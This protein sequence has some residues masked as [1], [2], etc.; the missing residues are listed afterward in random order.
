MNA[1]RAGL[2]VLVCAVAMT[3]QTY[4]F[5]PV[6]P[7]A[8][9][10]TT[11]TKKVT[12]KQLKPDLMLLIDKSGSMNDGENGG[13]ASAGNPRKMD[14]LKSVMNTFLMSEGRVARMGMT[15]YPA[16]ATCGASTA[17]E[18]RNG[19]TVASD[20]D[21]D[22]QAQANAVNT[23]LQSLT[24]GGGTPTAL[25]LQF[26]GT[27]PELNVSDRED[28]VLLLTDGL[29]NCNNNNAK[30]CTVGQCTCTVSPASACGMGQAYCTLGCL[31]TDGSVQAI[32][33]LRAKQIR[34]IVVG[35]GSDVAGGAAGDT[36]NAMAIAGGFQRTCPNGTAAECGT[37]NTCL[38]GNVCAKAYYQASNGTELAAALAQISDNLAGDGI[39]KY[40]LEAQP[41]SAD[42][43]SVIIDG[44][45]QQSGP[46]T[47]QLMNGQIVFPDTGA[48]SICAKLKLSDTTKPVTVEIRVVES[49]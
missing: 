3:C 4:D 48:T 1:L 33:D 47:W 2:S 45:P 10:Q 36:L 15:I 46:D 24:P 16:D 23:N 18:V 32:R 20:M 17:N 31:D 9:A 13:P 41:S 43:V 29:P 21:A 28:F 34:T 19:I 26:L 7:L 25:S 6:T 35:F 39:C 38:A 5:E 8:I 42:L 27:L 22:L 49:L 40:T 12:A 37:G 14:T 30:N 11:Q 44:V